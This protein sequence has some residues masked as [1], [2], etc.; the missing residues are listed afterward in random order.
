MLKFT[1]PEKTAAQFNNV[2]FSLTTPENWQ[3]IGDSPT[4][5]A[6]LAYLE[7][8]NTALPADTPV[9]TFSPLSA[10][11]VRKV[12]TQFNL[13]S[14]VESAINLADQNTKDAWQFANEF[15]RDNALLNAMAN[16]L[17]MSAAQLDKMFEVGANL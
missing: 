12:L 2:F 4:R 15:G 9:K 13:R 3:S 1:N 16:A 10:W 11:Q 17:G 8:G 14:Q 7:E 5:E 6:V